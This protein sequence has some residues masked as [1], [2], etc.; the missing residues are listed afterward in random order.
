MG[1]K[2]IILRGKMNKWH[3]YKGIFLQDVYAFVDH[4]NQ[5]R[6]GLHWLKTERFTNC[7][8]IEV[9]LCSRGE[10][11]FALQSKK[12]IRAKALSILYFASKPRHKCRG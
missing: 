2:V 6:K 4:L 1:M 3:A 7:I 11:S 12:H 5:H 10:F 8:S 9:P